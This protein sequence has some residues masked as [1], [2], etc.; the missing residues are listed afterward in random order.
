MPAFA[1]PFD[2]SGCRVCCFTGHRPEG[3]PQKEADTALLRLKLI[4][5]VQQ[6]A[7]AGADVFYAGARAG[8]TCS[9]R[10]PYCFCAS[11]SGCRSS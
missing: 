2:F 7:A 5:T 9:L 4:M 8:L 6:A 1:E 3:L 10:R 11:R